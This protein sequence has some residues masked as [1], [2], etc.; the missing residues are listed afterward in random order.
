MYRQTEFCVQ[1]ELFSLSKKLNN[2]VAY[3]RLYL[4]TPSPLHFGSQPTNQTVH[5]INLKRIFSLSYSGA[6][7][8]G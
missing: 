1:Y 8:P 7:E 6:A 5:L 4:S 2:I 3:I